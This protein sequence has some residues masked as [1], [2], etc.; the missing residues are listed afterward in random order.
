MK[1]PTRVVSPKRLIAYT[2][3]PVEFGEYGF[4]MKEVAPGTFNIVGTHPREIVQGMIDGLHGDASDVIR[5]AGQDASQWHHIIKAGDVADPTYCAAKV[6]SGLADLKRAMAA[7]IPSSE[8]ALFEAIR[9]ALAVGHFYHA[10]EVVLNEKA[11]VNL[12]D[13]IEAGRRGNPSDKERDKAIA[14]EFQQKVEERKLT[15]VRKSDTAIRKT[16]GLQFGI[17]EPAVRAAIKRAVRG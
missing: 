15:A 11:I 12:A 8:H 17:T 5:D 13:N 1:T 3:T 9:A 6:L 7:S 2:R 4:E 16:I 14:R 10:L